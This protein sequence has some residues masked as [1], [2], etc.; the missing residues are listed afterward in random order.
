MKIK[1]HVVSIIQLSVNFLNLISNNSITYPKIA[2]SLFYSWVFIII[3][4]FIQNHNKHPSKCIFHPY[5]NISVVSVVKFSENKIAE[6][7]DIH[8]KI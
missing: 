2:I 4:Y 5:V 3:I 8:F 6:S 7:K 1:W